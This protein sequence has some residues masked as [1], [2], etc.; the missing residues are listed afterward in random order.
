MN[1]SI[2]VQWTY[3]GTDDTGFLLERST[4]SGSTYPLR[5]GFDKNTFTYIDT[6][7][8]FGGTYWYKVAATNT[9][10]T[11]SF[12]NLAEVFLAP[13]S[14]LSPQATPQLT[15]SAILI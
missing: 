6:A 7:V 1:P 10:G 8:G 9:K 11:G 3:R 5:W 4:D 14:P 15:A 12:S 13:L 2:L